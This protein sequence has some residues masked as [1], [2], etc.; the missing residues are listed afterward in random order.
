MR[1]TR[2][3]MV[4]GIVAAGAVSQLGGATESRA[5]G[6]NLGIITDELTEN[7]GE[8][9]DFISSYSLRWCE[10]REIWGKNVMNLHQEELDSAKQLLAQKNVRV[11]DIASPIFKWNLPA[12]PAKSGERHDSFKADFT[13]EDADSLLEKS[14]QL[15][16]FFD[17][18]KVRI[19]SYLR[20]AEPEKAYP[21]V[22]DQLA[23]AAQ[24][25]AKNDIVLVLENEHSCN[26]GTGGELGR[27]LK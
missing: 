21:M 24:I 2:R 1:I 10:L 11:S 20:V 19:F 8:A 16:H 23:K 5:K 18:R 15:A 17:T 12:M 25:A 14:F 6:F 7:V 4:K 22:R 9:L 27:L 3:H 13:E 26:I